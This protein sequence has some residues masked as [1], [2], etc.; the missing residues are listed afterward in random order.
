MYIAMRKSLFSLRHICAATILS[1]AFSALLPVLASGQII[2]ADGPGAASLAST[3][4]GS[5]VVVL[6]PVLTCNTAANG[7]FTV[8]AISPLG[9]PY[10]IVLS[11]GS[12]GNAPG[13]G[14]AQAASVFST[15]SFSPS[16][17]DADLATVASTP[18]SNTHDACTLEFDFKAAGDSVKFDYVFASE[19]YPEYAC[20]GFND[21]FAFLISGGTTSPST[22]YPTPYNIARIPGTTIPVCI[23]SVNSAPIGTGYG[24]GTCNAVGPGS[25]FGV[26]YID[27]AASTT[28]VFDGMTKVMRAFAAV[29][30]CDTYHLKLGI[31]D[32]GDAAYD[33]GVF[34][35]GG[36]LTSTVPTTIS[37]VGTGA[38]PYYIRGCSP[39]SFL[40]STP[41]A[42]D[43]AV[44]VHYTVTG[45]AVNGYDYATLTGYAVIPAFTTSVAVTVNA[46]PVPPAGPRVVTVEIFKTDP[47]HPLDSVMTASSSITI[48]DS[49]DF[50]ILTPDTS[51]CLGQYVHIRAIGDT[52]FAAFL[53]YTWS[54]AGTLS[55]TTILTTDAT[56]AI[57]TT[58]TLTTTADASLGCVPQEKHITVSIYRNP[59]ITTDSPYVKTCVGVPVALHAAASPPGTPY[60]YSWSPGTYLT[61]TSIPDPVDN[62]LTPGD[63]TYTITVFPTAMPLC[64]SHDTI[65]VHTLP[66][67]F[68]ILTPNQ[69]ICIGDSIAT[70]VTG[71][72][73]FTWSWAPPATVSDPTIMEPTVAPTTDVVYTVTATY[74]HCPDMVHTL[75]IE[76]DHP[77]P[78]IVT[79]DTICLAMPF[80]VD[81]TVPGSTGVGNGYYH[82]QW[83]PSTFVSNDTIPNPSISP[84]VAGTYNYIVT[85]QPHAPGCAVNDN[86]NLYVLPNTINLV[87]PDTA[88]CKGMPLQVLATGDP[89]FNYQWTPTAGIAIS[90]VVA[91]FITPDTSAT[92]IVKFSFHLCPDFYDSLKVDVQPV[93]TVYIGGNRFV[94]QYDTIRM[95]GA[96]SPSWYTHYVYSWTPGTYLDHSTDQNVV[97]RAGDTSNIILT[98]TTPRGCK[99]V[100]SA[101]VNVWPGDFASMQ[102]NMSFCPHDTAVL[103]PEG[104]VSYHWTPSIYISDSMAARPVIKPITTQ[105][106]DVIAM[107]DKGCKDTLHFTAIVHPS[108]VIF[109]EDSVKLYPGETYQIV[110]QTNCSSFIWS[111]PGGLTNRFISDPVA[112]PEVTTRYFVMATTENGC[113]TR[114]SIDVIVDPSTIIDLPNAFAPGGGPNKEFK[115]IKRGIATLNYFRI[116]NRWGNIVFETKDIDKG[117]DGTYN[118]VPQPLGVFVYDVQAVTSTG[119]II[120]KHGNTTLLR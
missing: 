64:A 71:S 112:S 44:P 91:P 96:V 17:S 84:T 111:P 13:T 100:D 76:V 98:V 120:S 102:E 87:T 40:F 43:T 28:L 39:G 73:E 48:L 3:L 14:I 109:L 9:I 59:D 26:Y 92:Y 23:N 20:S 25:P 108:A 55:A 50:H 115:I 79:Y 2:V 60:T 12:V 19:E 29:S 70:S 97:F 63:I 22:S 57:T 47:C 119:I 37:G 61:G 86:I 5:G 27:N 110:P 34:I 72:L 77:A 95:Y 52:N 45:T 116:F 35:R 30:P 49:F 36:S 93:P 81:L 7:N 10:G 105:T 15:G 78:L 8:G 4:T 65:H 83:T 18:T 66:N 1:V 101:L 75:S 58:Y 31:A 24:I 53:H 46:L 103:A 117:W 82:Y 88:L 32:V 69:P 80:S 68:T 74:A 11:T 99:G 94:C 104:G 38:L 90:D 107:S 42:Q 106:Y 21:V 114:D 51:I 54:P 6:S 89:L 62:P 56:P 16:F 113:K 67:D 85:V 41:I 33:S 118:G